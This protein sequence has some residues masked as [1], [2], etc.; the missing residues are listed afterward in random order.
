MQQLIQNAA[1][2]KTIYKQACMVINMR[3]MWFNF[4][5]GVP[6]HLKPVSLQV[7]YCHVVYAF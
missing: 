4:E 7:T 2:P 3:T 5:F 1:F 6:S